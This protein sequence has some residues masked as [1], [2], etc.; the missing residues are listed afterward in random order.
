MVDVVGT[1]V[2]GEPVLVCRCDGS[3]VGGDHRVVVGECPPTFPPV[4]IDNQVEVVVGY[5]GAITWEV[6]SLTPAPQLASGQGFDV[7]GVGFK[8]CTS[9]AVRDL[10]PMDR[11]RPVLRVAPVAF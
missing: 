5:V 11:Q 1:E 8:V 2:D 4:R 9:G 10:V 3:G 6:T 7:L